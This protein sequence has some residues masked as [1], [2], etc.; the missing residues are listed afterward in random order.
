VDDDDGNGAHPGALISGKSCPA[1]ANDND[2]S[3]GKEDTQG[4]PK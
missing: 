3:G 4:G 2:D 1:D